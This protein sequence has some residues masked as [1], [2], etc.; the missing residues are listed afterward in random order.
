MPLISIITPVYN[1]ARFLPDTLNSVQAQTL[2]DWEH[3]LVDD[4]SGDG[5]ANI[6]NAA[7]AGDA[8]IRLLRTPC[9]S[10]PAVA[11][12]LALD[13]ARG[14]YIAFLDADDLWLARKLELCIDWMQ[15]HGHG[16][17]YHDYR[18]MSEDGSRLGGLISGPDELNLRTVHTRRGHGGCLSMMIDRQ[19]IGDV[20][21]PP[22]SHL[23]HE[24]LRAWLAIIRKGFVGHRVP[25]DLGRYRLANTSRNAK[26]FTSISHTWLIYR[27][28]PE[29]SYAKAAFWWLQYVWNA[30][31]MYR[32]AQP[33]CGSDCPALDERRNSPG[34]PF[35]DGFGRRRA[36]PPSGCRKWRSGVQLKP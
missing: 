34:C 19:Q 13:A 11:R 33:Q 36:A 14:R 16:F 18:H 6:V 22:R 27:N 29:L 26:K 4:G 7:S 20:R 35:V 31:R 8:R 28:E 21:F 12:N 10:G 1:A 17:V 15:S 3:L 2:T 32:Y 25:C 5:S 30:W 24:D 9:N 23:T